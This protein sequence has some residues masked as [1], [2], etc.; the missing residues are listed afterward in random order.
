MIPV[1]GGLNLSLDVGDEAVFSRSFTEADLSLFVGIS[2]DFNP[3]HVDAAFMAE[4]EFGRPILPG[5]LVA[6]MLTHIGGMWA[7]LAHEVSFTFL[8]PVYTGQ[9][10]TLKMKIIEISPKNRATFEAVWTNEEGE[11]VLTGKLHGYPPRAKERKILT[12]HR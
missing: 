10:V 12:R 8:K 9:T 1:K 6:S 4:T 5:L 3:Y 2:G 7:I 11:E